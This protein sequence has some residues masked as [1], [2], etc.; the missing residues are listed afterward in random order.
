M[1]RRKCTTIPRTEGACLNQNT[2]AGTTA[3]ESRSN[4][5]SHPIVRFHEPQVLAFGALTAAELGMM[6][7]A[8]ATL[9]TNSLECS[10]GIP[11]PA[12]SPTR[13]EKV[14]QTPNVVFVEGL[15]RED[16]RWLFYYDG[17]D[18]NAGVAT[19]PI[20]RLQAH[21]A[22]MARG[23]T[24]SQRKPREPLTDRLAWISRAG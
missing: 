15:V 1:L 17:A 21:E 8:P 13:W 20:L 12:R 10:T 24:L 16:K 4:L 11:I 22:R 9:S 5:L 3:S 14:G 7:E 19:A 6:D 2:G 18:K 23:R